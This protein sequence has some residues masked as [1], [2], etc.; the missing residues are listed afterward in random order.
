M[1]K[2]RIAE[3]VQ[4]ALK[5]AVAAGA[6]EIS[7]MPPIE[8]EAPR[9]KAFGDYS[10]NVALALA[11]QV[12][13]PPH[14]VARR[15]IE[16][17]EADGDL[18][19]KAEVA[20]A[21]FINFFLKSDWLG[22]VLRRIA[23]EGER[24]GHSALHTGEKVLVE[25]VSAN[26]NGPIT[27][28]SA[29][30]G[31][32]GDVLS[33]LLEATGYEVCR[34]YYVNDA[35]NSLQ[36][37]HF[38]KSL[39]ARYLQALGQEVEF[40]EDGYKG[41]YVTQIARQ[42]VEK[43]GDKYL[44]L[45]KAERVRKFT[46]IGEREMLALQKADLEAFGVEFDNWYSERSLHDSGKV[47]K[48]IETL[49]QKG[50]AYEGGGALWLK[51]TAFG[52]DK[53]RAL[54]RRNGQPT[55]IASDTAYHADKFDRGFGKLVNVWGPQHHGYVARTKAAVAALGYDPD[56]LDIII[57]QTVRLF[58]GGELVMMSKRAG[59]LIPLGELVEEV[60]RDTSR[61]FLLMRTAD[62]SLDFDL[63]LAKQQSSE[64]PVF[65]VQYAHARI[66]SI[67]RAAD[68]AGVAVPAASDTDLSPLGHESE[69]ELVKKLAEYPDEVRVAAETYQPHRLTAYARDLASIFHA[70][71]RDCRVLGD[72]PAETNARLV[73]VDSARTTLRN[74]LTTLGVTAPDRM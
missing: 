1:I 68:E 19:E 9:N 48:A 32:I 22:D 51:S 63:E 14:E 54:I 4:A 21:G 74:V 31:A 17:L 33:N 5:S 18:I 50:Y 8:L 30:G 27:V 16:H 7:E 38:G 57:Y 67:L 44:S 65:Y 61:F 64:N 73:L 46:D 58:S 71:Y 55:Y 24:Y 49:K 10:T 43:V 72:D 39:E 66:S 36:M 25:Y 60:G 56:N 13:M 41:E 26:P 52:D 29:R 12:K 53:D 62:S 20:G 59:E 35:V 6:L 45:P 40:P 42:I 11:G 23:S 47:G 69:I 28:G 34:E 15:V 3:L 37:Q 2:D 70:F